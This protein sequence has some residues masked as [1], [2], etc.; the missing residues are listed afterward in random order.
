MANGG[1]REGA[2]RKPKQKVKLR[3]DSAIDVLAV[4][5]GELDER[6]A[7]PE[8]QHVLKFVRAQD[9]RLGWEV[10][11]YTKECVDGKP[12]QKIPDLGFDPDKPLRVVVDHIGR[13]KDQV[14]AEAKHSAAHLE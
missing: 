4:I 7:S 6:K 10:Y 5:N 8:V 14:A 3:K 9:L 1:R 2:G 11:R 12:L 13:P